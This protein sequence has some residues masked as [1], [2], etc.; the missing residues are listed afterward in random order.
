M[1]QMALAVLHTA[2]AIK[3]HCS[4]CVPMHWINWF[5]CNVM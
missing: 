5:S 3:M 2:S 4:Y 1:N